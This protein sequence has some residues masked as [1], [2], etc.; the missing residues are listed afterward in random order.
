[1]NNPFDMTPVRR[2]IREIRQVMVGPHY[3]EEEAGEYSALRIILNDG[4]LEDDA[5]TEQDAALDFLRELARG[6]LRSAGAHDR[7]A[8]KDRKEAE[9]LLKYARAVRLWRERDQTPSALADKWMKVAAKVREQAG[10]IICDNHGE[11]W[12][13]AGMQAHHDTLLACAAEVEQLRA[14]MGE[15]LELHPQTDALIDQ[16]AVALKDKLTKAQR[17][18]GFTN[19]WVNSDW[20]EQCQAELLS[21]LDKGDPRDVA[22]YAAFCWFHGWSTKVGG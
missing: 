11:L 5:K 10:D 14:V 21:H 7:W 20:K 15:S 9:I 4:P 22:A 18:Y 3:G 2:R 16:F 19:N 17:K 6:A 13:D 1:M 12:P 8:V